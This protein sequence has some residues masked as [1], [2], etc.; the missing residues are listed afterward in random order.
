MFTTNSLCLTVCPIHEWYLF[1]KIFKTNL[2][3]FALWKTSS[4]LILSDH[5][6]VHFC[7]WNSNTE[8]FLFPLWC[9]GPT[10][11]MASSFLRFLDHTQWCITVGRNPLDEWSALSRDLYLTK[12]N[13]HD[14]QISMPPVGFEPTISAGKRPQTYDVDRMVTGTGNTE[15][16]HIYIIMKL[17]YFT[18]NTNCNVPKEMSK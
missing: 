18:S 16:L 4:F 10:L 3:F 6:I 14:R 11:A 2:P 13:T 15:Y 12:H 17:I 9:C 7:R 8:Y 5:F 1:F